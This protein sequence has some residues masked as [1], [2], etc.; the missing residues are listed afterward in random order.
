[1]KID[2]KALA[3]AMVLSSISVFAV[4]I[5]YYLIVRKNKRKEEVTKEENDRKFDK[6]GDIGSIDIHSEQAGSN[7]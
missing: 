3:K 5:I 2:R 4:P 7:K 1:M 6:H